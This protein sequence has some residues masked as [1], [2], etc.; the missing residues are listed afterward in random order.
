MKHGIVLLALA[1]LSAPVYAQSDDGR[2]QRA[3]KSGNESSAA[4]TL[5]TNEEE[6]Q[7]GLLLPA[8]QKVR[9]SAATSEAAGVEPDEIDARAPR[10]APGIEPD[11]IDAKAPRATSATKPGGG[12]TGQS[13]RRAAALDDD[14]DGDSIPT[15]E[16][17]KASP[18][19]Q[20]P[21]AG[22]RRHTVQ[23]MMVKLRPRTNSLVATQPGGNTSPADKVAQPG[24]APRYEIAD[25]GTATSPMVCCHHEQ[26]DGSTCNMFK[27]LC[28]NAGGTAQGDGTDATCSDWP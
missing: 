24:Q 18:K 26:G 17:D 23:Q 28:E 10:A 4:G 22:G 1:S 13:R 16:I 9:E 14:S 3:S 7:A 6:E 15:R 19:L 21:V 12:M 5:R 2:P 8:V 25:C 20:Q 11:E 27:M